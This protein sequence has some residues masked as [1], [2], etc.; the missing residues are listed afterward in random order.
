[1]VYK[2]TPSTTMKIS[3]GFDFD[4]EV[5]K[6]YLIEQQ[7]LYHKYWENAGLFKKINKSVIKIR[8]IIKFK[9]QFTGRKITQLG[10]YIIQ[11]IF[12]KKT[13]SIKI[14]GYT[15]KSIFSTVTLYFKYG[16]SVL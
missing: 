2:A 6:P 5:F 12:F 15:L 13:H 14:N 3:V 11:L 1:M 9:K 10:E 8:C 4:P 7:K 16:K